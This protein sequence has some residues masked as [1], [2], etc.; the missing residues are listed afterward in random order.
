MWILY[1]ICGDYEIYDDDCGRRS[2]AIHSIQRIRM[3]KICCCRMILTKMM[4]MRMKTYAWLLRPLENTK[5]AIRINA[6]WTFL[7][8]IFALTV[9]AHAHSAK[10]I[11]A[12]FDILAQLN[13][14]F[15]FSNN[16]NRSWKEVISRFIDISQRIAKISTSPHHLS[17]FDLPYFQYI[18][19]PST[20]QIL[21][22]THVQNTL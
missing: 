12:N 18:I 11:N 22:I 3:M 7:L 19:C 15:C 8:K 14:C 16:L 6:N 2:F 4:M 20:T 21:V 5:N 13:H 9:N 1:L 10:T 17:T